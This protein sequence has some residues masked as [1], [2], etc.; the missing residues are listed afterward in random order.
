MDRPCSHLGRQEIVQ[1]KI[2]IG[3][4]EQEG[5]QGTLP[6][7]QIPGL[8]EALGEIEPSGD[9]DLALEQWQQHLLHV[10][11]V[12]FLEAL[13]AEVRQLVGVR[14]LCK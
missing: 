3:Q 13:A 7:R 11:H 4:L 12:A 8:V 9:A 10:V 5:H 2:Q 14:E 1:I 6:G